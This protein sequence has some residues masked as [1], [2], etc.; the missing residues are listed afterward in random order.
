VV[1]VEAHNLLS[2]GGSF[3]WVKHIGM[4]ETPRSRLEQYFEKVMNAHSAGGPVALV[5]V[6]KEADIQCA[7]EIIEAMGSLTVAVNDMANRSEAASKESGRVAAESA[8][9][10]RKLNRL[11]VWI[12]IA[13]IASAVAA[14]VQAWV[15]FIARS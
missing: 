12:V 10:S 5:Q 4:T 11:T 7:I 14:C 6:Q 3:T 15:A 8:N 13:A 2:C 1:I 9:L